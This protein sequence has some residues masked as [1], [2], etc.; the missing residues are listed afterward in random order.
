MLWTFIR[1]NSDMNVYK[2]CYTA[3]AVSFKTDDK[4]WPLIDLLNAESVS[5]LLFIYAVLFSDVNECTIGLVPGVPCFNG[6][7]CTNTLG[8]YRCQCKKGWTGQNC[9]IGTVVII[10]YGQP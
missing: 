4:L 5:Y 2:V 10:N 3:I 6:G 7:T 8:S 1:T 9:E